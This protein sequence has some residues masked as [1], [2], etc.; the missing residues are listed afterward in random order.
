M[1]I[2]I[3]VITIFGFGV[4]R[5]PPHIHILV[6]VNSIPHTKISFS[7][8]IQTI[9]SLFRCLPTNTL[10]TVSL[11]SHQIHTHAK[12]TVQPFL[13]FGCLQTKDLVWVL[14]NQISLGSILKL[15]QI[16]KC[17]FCIFLQRENFAFV[18]CF[19]MC[20]E[21]ICERITTNITTNIT[22]GT[23]IIIY[24]TTYITGQATTGVIYTD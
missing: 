17:H 5:C 22:F 3:K 4:L 6:T 2:K 19:C 14:T 23:N 12:Y 16:L 8:H 18:I 13:S 7:I 15:T 1:P 20:K 21:I 24:I 11:W 10:P 9:Y